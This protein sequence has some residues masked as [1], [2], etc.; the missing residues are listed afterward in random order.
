NEAKAKINALPDLIVIGITGSYGK[1]STKFYLQKI[2]S[3]K[4]NVLMTPESYN[5]TMGV[6]RTVNE[7]LKPWH[8]VFVC[9]M[10]AR[11]MG[12]IKEICDIVRPTYGIL[13]SVGIAHLETFRTT[14]NI[15]KTKF[16]LV[17]SIPPEGL[18]FLNVDSPA[19]AAAPCA[20]PHRT[21]GF[22]P[23]CDCRADDL[24]I[25]ERGTTFTLHCRGFEPLTLT[26]RLL[27]RHN[28]LNITGAAGLALQMGVPP[29][30]LAVALRRLKP[31]PHRLE[32]K[33]QGQTIVI[34]D[35]YNSNPEGAAEAVRVLGSL[36]DRRRILVTPGMVEL[37]EN[38]YAANR[39][40]GEQAAACCDDVIAVGRVKEALFEGLDLGGFDRSRRHAVRNLSEALALLPTLLDRPAAVLLENDLTDDLEG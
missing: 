36:K 23:D 1:T 22:S 7:Q 19:V 31:V 40:F 30:A 17:D 27:G 26:T 14:E 28:V 37:G 21:Y 12:D 29:Q 25:D 8:Q 5:T 33:N 15:R 9:E 13:T 39:D 4:Y 2:L 32:L 34:D 6:V 11:Q 16:E 20:T 24:Q 10:G 18:A 35:A 38:E 3:S